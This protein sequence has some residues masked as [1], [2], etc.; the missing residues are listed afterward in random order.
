VAEKGPKNGSWDRLYKVRKLMKQK[1]V[2][3]SLT[4]LSAEFIGAEAANPEETKPRQP[5]KGTHV[6]PH[7]PRPDNL[8][9]ITSS[10]G[11]RGWGIN[12]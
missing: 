9:I 2:L 12:E 7:I 10:A 11:F 1:K 6:P 8:S 3:K 5:Q 4:D